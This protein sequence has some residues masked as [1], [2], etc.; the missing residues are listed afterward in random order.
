[1]RIQHINRKFTMAYKHKLFMTSINNTLQTFLAVLQIFDIHYLFMFIL[2]A[3]RQSSH[4]D[5][6]KIFFGQ[7]FSILYINYK[8]LM[9]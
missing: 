4:S 3:G 1:M 7:N 5:P 9:L 6:I 8:Y 2:S